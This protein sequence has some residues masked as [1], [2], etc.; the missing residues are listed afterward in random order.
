MRTTITL[1]DELLKKAA[2]ICGVKEKSK[3]VNL[4]LK[5]MVDADLLERFLA[6][7]GTMPDLEY[8]EREPRMNREPLPIKNDD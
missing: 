7:E 3:L 8:F 5:K 1:D 6:L 2:K 4:A